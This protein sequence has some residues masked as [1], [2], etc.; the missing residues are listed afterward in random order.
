VRPERLD[1]LKN[2]MTFTDAYEERD[3]VIYSIFKEPSKRIPVVL[4]L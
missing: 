1:Q 3:K 2:S 4:T